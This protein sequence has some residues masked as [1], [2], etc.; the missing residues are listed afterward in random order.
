M[1]LRW[2]QPIE[3]G[4]TRGNFEVIFTE[5]LSKENILQQNFSKGVEMEYRE[6]VDGLRPNTLYRVV[7]SAFKVENGVIKRSD[8]VTFPMVRTSSGDNGCFIL[9]DCLHCHLLLLISLNLIV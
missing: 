5:V 2:K 3:E 4:Q 6:V 1:S 9:F 8:S 7:I